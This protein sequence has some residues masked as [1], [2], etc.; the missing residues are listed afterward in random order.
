MWKTLP[1]NWTTNCTASHMNIPG[2]PPYTSTCHLIRKTEGTGL[3]MA[4]IIFLGI[5][6][7]LA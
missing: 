3:L 4:Q 6:K 1:G 7:I 2:L 5:P